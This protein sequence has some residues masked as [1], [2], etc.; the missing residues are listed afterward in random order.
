MEAREGIGQ[1]APDGQLPL[2]QDHGIPLAPEKDSLVSSGE[3]FK[4]QPPFPPVLT[5]PLCQETV[6]R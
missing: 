1:A 3:S 2:E 6:V 4:T 5:Y